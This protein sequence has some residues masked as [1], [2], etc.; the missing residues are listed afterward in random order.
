[1]SVGRHTAW[2]VC[3]GLQTAVLRLEG[4]PIAMA[5]REHQLA[6]VWQSA[7]AAS[8]VAP[9]TIRD[10][11][12]TSALTACAAARI[13]PTLAQTTFH[14]GPYARSGHCPPLLLLLRLRPLSAGGLRDAALRCV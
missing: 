13:G 5:A 2:A 1:M 4:P 7:G 11:G 9:R 12:W 6:V 14:G 10:P 3:A 8:Q